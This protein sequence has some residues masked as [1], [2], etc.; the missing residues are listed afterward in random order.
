MLRSKMTAKEKLTYL[1][2]PM[3]FYSQKG[4]L[5]LKQKN[6]PYTEQIID[7]HGGETH[8]PGYVENI[9]PQGAV[10]VL[11]IEKDGHVRYIPD[12]EEIIKYLEENYPDNGPKLIPAQG[13]KERQQVDEFMALFNPLRVDL[14]TY[15][16]ILNPELTDGMV[17]PNLMRQR[18]MT[19]LVTNAERLEVLKRENPKLKDV[20]QSKIDGWVDRKK[21][22]TDIRAVAEIIDNE[23]AP[24]MGKIETTLAQRY[25]ASGV[26]G[27]WL[28][29]DTYTAADNYLAVLLQRLH[30]IGLSKRF[31]ESNIYIN[32][33]YKQLKQNKNFYDVCIRI[34]I[35]MHVVQ[36][37]Q[38]LK[39]YVAG[40]AA[41][42]VVAGLGYFLYKKYIK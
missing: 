1:H 36:K 37:L 21:T 25:E 6:I 24:L 38:A 41:A 32:R 3:S 15:G 16:C 17:F 42:S 20:Y 39:P 35:Q 12:S 8:S 4:S 22:M 27:T 14:I 40:L 29:S 2:N 13:S 33:Y 5:A 30:F 23:L 26:N 11:K 19:M 7:L 34:A 28:C 10:P 31:I 18:A 9:N